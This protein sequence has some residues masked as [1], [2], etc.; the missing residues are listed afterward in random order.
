LAELLADARPLAATG[1]FDPE[2][3]GV[4]EHEEAILAYAAELAKT[5]ER[6]PAA[7]GLRVADAD[8]ALAVHATAPDGPARVEALE[9]AARA[10]LGDAFRLVPEIELG[11]EQEDELIGALGATQSGELTRWLTDEAGVELPVDEWLYGVARVREQLAAWE[12]VVMLAGGFGLPEPELVPLQLPHVAGASWL[13]LRFPEDEAIACEHLLYTAHLAVAPQQGERVCGLLLDEW[14]EVLP[15]DEAVTGIALHHD[16]PNAE[17]PQAL[18]LVTPA[19]W[20]GTWH[21]EDLVGAL[22]ETLD[23]AKARA[24]EPVHVDATPY[25]RFLP[26]TVMAAT[27]RGMTIGAVL[28]ANN[29]ALEAIADG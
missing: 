1:A 9:R 3:F 12:A 13:A 28:A 25:A 2:P 16:R 22:D 24:V 10:M 23:L 19:A 4:A 7:I 27:L 18:L 15:G 26:A 17:A 14:T 5:L 11:S 20:D 8:T 21:A 6:T 29:H